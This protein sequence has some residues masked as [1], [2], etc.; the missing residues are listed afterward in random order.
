MKTE[1]KK[2][3]ASAI[4]IEVGPYK[5]EERTKYGG[6]MGKEWGGVATMADADPEWGGHREIGRKKDRTV[7]KVKSRGF[8]R[9]VLEE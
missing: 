4:A 1:E 8:E 2:Q 9:G 7:Q 5:Q 3:P 6:S